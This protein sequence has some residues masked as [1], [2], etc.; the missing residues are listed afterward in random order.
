MSCA[1]PYPSPTGLVAPIPASV[2]WRLKSNRHI[3]SL[4]L[5][6]ECHPAR[7]RFAKAADRSVKLLAQRIANDCE[8]RFGNGEPSYTE[9]PH[10]NLIGPVVFFVAG[11]AVDA[12]GK[13]YGCGAL[14]IRNLTFWF[15]EYTSSE[16]IFWP[17][18]R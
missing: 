2:T 14:Q 8:P 18:R 5:R 13:R 17:P 11:I 10:S 15:T 4:A 9:H 16:N 12:D 3:G 7:P 1:E 6:T